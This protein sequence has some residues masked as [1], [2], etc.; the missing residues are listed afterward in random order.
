MMMKHMSHKSKP[1]QKPNIAFRVR[2]GGKSYLEMANDVCKYK[3]Q[4]L[5]CPTT[6]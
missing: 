2:A 4:A 3:C 6:F 5:L 1:L